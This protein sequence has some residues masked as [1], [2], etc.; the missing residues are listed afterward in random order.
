MFIF[1]VVPEVVP[2]VSSSVFEG[3]GLS[4]EPSTV[5]VGL[6][7]LLFGSTTASRTELSA[8]MKVATART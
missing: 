1:E 8:K 3:V 6:P 7:E 2:C 5:L 4:I